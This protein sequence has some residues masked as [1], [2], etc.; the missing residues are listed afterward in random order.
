MRYAISSTHKNSSM[1]LLHTIQ[2]ISFNEVGKSF[3]HCD[4]SHFLITP[5]TLNTGCSISI[6]LLK[7]HANLSVGPNT[8]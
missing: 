1:K 7:S 6:K 4:F 2:K 3:G 5:I 8:K